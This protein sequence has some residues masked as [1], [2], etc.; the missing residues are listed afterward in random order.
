MTRN[1]KKDE[2]RKDSVEYLREKKAKDGR[3]S[4]IGEWLLSGKGKELGWKVSPEN[5]KYILR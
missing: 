2:D 1:M 5:M 4:K 3:L